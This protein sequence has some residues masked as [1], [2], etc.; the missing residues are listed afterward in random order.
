MYKA[1]LN[2]GIAILFFSQSAFAES[3]TDAAILV[4]G[5]PITQ[6][7]I[8]LYAQKRL[9]V[10]YI[11][12]LPEQKK[13]ELF[14]EII[15][16]ELVYQNALSLELEKDPEYALQLEEVIKNTLLRIRLNKVLEDNPPTEKELK[17]VYK[18]EIAEPASREYK[19]RH[20][21]VSDEHEA[22]GIIDELTKGASFEKLAKEF[23]TGPSKTDGGELGW[24]GL[25]QMVKPFSDALVKLNK[26]QY[27]QRPVQTRFGW[28]VIL[29]EDIRKVEPPSFESVQPQVI[30][31]VQ[32]RIISEFIETLRNAPDVEI[33]FV[34][35]GE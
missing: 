8:G 4:N 26:G 9:G 11:D 35:A 19:A 2:V 17:K 27:T 33:K 13:Q 32:N 31:I 34:T 22:K 21:L 12:S 6:T 25:S 7:S 20:I 30:E 23:S 10:P 18:S 29:L 14:D 28:H 5:K 16:R 24:F 3:E 1:L 15:N